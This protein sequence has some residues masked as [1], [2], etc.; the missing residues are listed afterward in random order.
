MKHINH[1]GFSL[2]EILLTITLLSILFAILVN[3]INPSNILSEVQDNQR[4]A[5]ALT[6]YQ[7]LEQYA[8]KNNTYPEA[9]K[10]M[11][12]N[13]SAYICKTSAPNCNNT[14][15]INLSTILVPT[16]LS[17]I[18]EYSTDTNNSGFYVVKDSNGKIGIGGVRRLDDT[19]FVKGLENQSFATAPTTPKLAVTSCTYADK[20]ISISYT[21]GEVGY[22][23]ASQ[24]INST[25]V[26]GLTAQLLLEDGTLATGGDTTTDI[27]VGEDTYRVHTF[28]TVG[29]SSLNVIN[30]GEFEYL[31]VG[32]GGG[33]G[34]WVGGGGGAGG[35]RSSV[36]G[37]SSGG[38]ASAESPLV[39][40]A[41]SYTVTVGAGGVGNRSVTGP[42]NTT[43]GTNGKDSSFGP[44]TAIGG[45]RGGSYSLTL[46]SSGGSGGGG[47][48]IS[49]GTNSGTAGQGYAG[50]TGLD[51]S[52]F[53]GGGGGGAGGVG[54]AGTNT[55]GGRGGD[56]GSGVSSSING[57]ATFR[58][59]GGGGGVNSPGAGALEGVGGNGGGGNG[60]NGKSDGSVASNGTA[61]TGGGGGGSGQANTNP[62]SQGGNGGSGI[63]IVRY[64][65]TGVG[66]LASS[67][68]LEYLVNGTPSGGGTANFNLSN[69][70]NI[71][72]GCNNS[73]IAVNVTE[74]VLDSNYNNVALLIN[75]NGTNGSTSI[76]DSS[77]N[78]NTVAAFGNSQ[79]SNVQSKFGGSSVYFD[80]SGDYLRIPVSDVM[81]FGSGDY[82]VEAW[83][84][85]NWPSYSTIFDN[86]TG[87]SQGVGFYTGQSNRI[88]VANNSAVIIETGSIPVNT[89]TH[90]AISR[91]SNVLRAFI[92]GVKIG[93][94]TD[95]RVYGTSA[96]AYIGANEGLFQT[97]AG[98]MD[99]LRVTKGVA[100]YNSNFTPTTTEFP[101]SGNILTY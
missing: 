29:T 59:G 89:W 84:Y 38:G 35:Y 30:G 55:S 74:T 62:S 91:Q 63:V 15:Q 92:N 26:T 34:S 10:N 80:G 40:T 33:G 25:G 21:S 4:E 37:E 52:T 83:V 24:T 5:D 32:G 71:G 19:T 99:D 27:T 31:V 28:T 58:A 57:T 42:S 100:R 96:E 67:G 97:F 43:V 14:N 3:S 61:N 9:I 50:G 47:S 13:S 17:K 79:I 1:K 6:I 93:E 56:G 48:P 94:V 77:S 101:T 23:Y 76:I 98:Y 8:L 75:G 51:S 64:K 78:S 12:N 46:R 88:T 44:I 2:L 54:A 41:G 72:V 69:I 90:V 85:G 7:A 73:N 11:P 49:N 36:A 86:R 87:G 20:K 45:G 95:S 65:L 68:T 39:L 70:S 22:N 82:T 60:A 18:P 66:T 53:P 81:G 16:Y